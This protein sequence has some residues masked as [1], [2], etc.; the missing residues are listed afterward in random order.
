[1]CASVFIKE[2]GCEGE[3]IPVLAA[4]KTREIE[5]AKNCN[6]NGELRTARKIVEKRKIKGFMCQRGKTVAQLLH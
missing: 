5:K 4:I 2:K 6:A 3:T 1:M